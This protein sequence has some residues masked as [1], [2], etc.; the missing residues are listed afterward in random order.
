MSLN[1]M[2]GFAQTITL[3]GNVQEKSGEPIIG[4]SIVEKGT[5]NGNVTDIDGNFSLKVNSN[6][7]IVV[8]YMGMLT[9]EIKVAGRSSISVVMED[10]VVALSD[11]VVIG[12]GVQKRR[13][14]TGSVASVTSNDINAVPVSNVSQALQGKLPGVNVT[15]MDGRPDASVKIR[16]RGGGSITQ[17][18]DP[19]FVVDGFPVSNIN[20]I[21]ADQIESIDVLKDASSTAIY[22]ARGAN[23]VILVTTKSGKSGK[24]NITYNGY[25][26]LMQPTKK[27]KVLDSY[28]YVLA[29]W[30]Y[31]YLLNSN[32]GDTW[33]RAMGLGKYSNWTDGN[34]T[35]N[36]PG[37]I[38][39]YR[40][41]DS[42]DV[43][44]DIINDSFSHSHN[45]SISGGGEKTKYNISFNYIDNEGIKIYSWFRRANVLAKISQDISK[46][47]KLDVNARY[48]DRTGFGDE[49]YRSGA[50]SLITRSI[51]YI[52]VTAL[53][54]VSDA[55]TGLGMYQLYV[56]EKY[57]PENLIYD[58][59]NKRNYKSLFG[60]A[61]LTWEIIKDLRFRTEIGY[62]ESWIENYTYQGSLYRDAILGQKGSSGQIDRNTAN[63]YRFVNTLSYT[64]PGLGEKQNLDAMIGQELSASEGVN[65]RM[66]AQGY[67]STFDADKVYAM[68]NQYDPTMSLTINNSQKYPER[69]L[70]Y[71]G[72]V[73]YSLL[74]RYLLTATL[75]ADGS[76]I[77]PSDNQWGYFPAAAIGWRLSD[78]A[79]IK[80]LT[81]IDNL[82]VRL[83]Y[84]EVGNNRIDPGLWGFNWQAVSDNRY[85]Y[86][87]D[88]ILQPG[89][90]PAS[91]SMPNKGLKWETTITRNIG[92]DYSFINGRIFGA[93]DFYRNTTKDLLLRNNIP[94]YTGYTNIME[95][96]G[97]VRNQGL[98]FSVGGDIIR[99]KDLRITANFNINFNKNKI[100]ELSDDSKS[101]YYSTQWGSTMTVPLEYMFQEG[102]PIG[103]I[104]GYVHDG[105]YTTDDFNYTNGK[106]VL[107]EGVADNSSIIGG[108]PA[109]PYPGQIKFK[110]MGG[111][112][113]KL[114]EVDDVVEIGDTN[115]IHTGGFNLSGQ[116]KGF[117]A[118]FAFNWSYGNDVF[119]ADKMVN[120]YGAKTPYRNWLEGFE[121][122]YRLFDVRNGELVRIT[123]PTEL[124]ELNKNATTYYPYHE[125]PVTTSEAIED[126]SFLR[127]N[128]ITIGY[129]LP[130]SLT[131]KI[132]IQK[133]RVYATVYNVYVWTNYSGYDPEVDTGS[134]ISGAQYPMPGLDFGSY[135]KSRTYTLGINLNF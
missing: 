55:N 34:V 105:F 70:S 13:D 18:N 115:P 6:A 10:N 60:N 61:A 86:P 37:G 108:P 19:L 7:T 87:V 68:F 98:E 76:S 110:K 82:K 58:V 99:K 101:V 26:Q 62:T 83:S 124:A 123:D 51:R 77:F 32:N 23:G 48:V 28:E 134:N 92:L 91:T 20:D 67:P 46:T 24:V 89:Y 117:D 132:A 96:V 9:Q 17:S 31:D 80:D 85:K 39:S 25:V 40:N 16:V 64:I 111:T 125:I 49:S 27:T 65:S 128:N 56:G 133:L 22:G 106:Y 109:G 84:G 11:V 8:S 35:I 1:T 103:L 107:K 97:S 102:S 81:W 47:L 30:E 44:G 127:L 94:G 73:N 57:D 21:P 54:D 116:Y 79:F 131:R 71:F 118:L 126:G 100:V 78:E 130:E 29:N 135:P 72:R 122:R 113:S 112:G 42:R 38:E 36:N 66:A 45:L 53:G 74:D 50:G 69:M 4:A 33:A 90:E 95:N 75:R 52:P 15:S 88:G 59:Y 114:T 5:T 119:N 120:S 121:N 3:S 12:Y 14:L 93:V 63:E 129:T 2:T 43:E 104:R 41:M